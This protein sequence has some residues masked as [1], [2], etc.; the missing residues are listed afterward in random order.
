VTDNGSCDWFKFIEFIQNHRN[1]YM[2]CLS[3]D[4]KTNNTNATVMC[5]LHVTRNDD[6]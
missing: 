3:L 1:I 4:T 6:L 2:Q 5:I